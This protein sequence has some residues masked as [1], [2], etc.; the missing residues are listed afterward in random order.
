MSLLMEA[1]RKAEK[2]K[3]QKAD[4]GETAVQGTEEEGAVV[5]VPQTPPDAS[6]REEIE[7]PVLELSDNEPLVVE[8]WEE[9]PE[10]LEETPVVPEQAD[11]PTGDVEIAAPEDMSPM[12]PPVTRLEMEKGAAAEPAAKPEP[13]VAPS[14]VPNEAAPVVDVGPENFAEDSRQA[15][16][17]VFLAKSRRKRQVF[18]RKLLGYG[19]LVLLGIGS[20]VGYLY[21]SAKNPTME[22]KSF[23]VVNT[24]PPLPESMQPQ[25]AK[26]SDPGPP[27]Q[28]DEMSTEN[29]YADD[30][31]SDAQSPMGAEAQSS[32]LEM[33][34]AT[35]L[36]PETVIGPVIV[37]AMETSP[38][39]D[40][41]EASY[42]EPEPL[43]VSEM[44][45][46]SPP[47]ILISRRA[48]TPQS[49]TLLTSANSAFE[50]GQYRK[51]R[52]GYQQI[53]QA[54]PDH[55]GALLGLAALARRGQDQALARD[56]YLRV[57]TRDPADPLAKAG[58]LSVMAGGD[59]VRLESELKLLLEI[60]PDLAPLF[61]LLGN[62]Y[63]AG[64]RW[65]EAQEAYFNAVQ[66]AGKNGTPVP[67]YSFNLGVSLEHL[68]QP[69]LA[70]RYYREAVQFSQ[71]RQVGF[72]REALLRRLSELES[73]V[74]Q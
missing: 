64:Q 34:G 70:A 17:T 45:A 48:V 30:S 42:M 61:F 66:Q 24:S 11:D 33:D 46:A 55:R 12:P 47:P 72:D 50:L 26:M 1:L 51:S 32:P 71:Q 59:P 10:P 56:L 13:V 23:P 49:D 74:S 40:L 21:L 9:G 44:E 68:G 6:D 63:A 37:D 62:L 20:A 22:F 57:L 60:H 16:Q 73:G 28:G 69:V 5:A 19:M 27:L 4:M 31:G 14:P 38:L 18:R 36:L 58:L 3:K 65:N 29:E 54:D 25:P 39:A 52:S 2:V 53:L 8:E 41:P 15:A 7:S 67:D 35:R 43:D